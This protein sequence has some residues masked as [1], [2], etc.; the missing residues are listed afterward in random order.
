S[1]DGNLQ[2]RLLQFL[3]PGL[4]FS[5]AFDQPRGMRGVEHVILGHRSHAPA[6]AQRLGLVRSEVVE[7]RDRAALATV[8]KEMQEIRVRFWAPT[9]GRNHVDERKSQYVAIEGDCLAQA[10]SGTRRVVY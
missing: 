2:S 9:A 7:E 8:E 5:F 3:F 4:E 10:P 6:S 1:F